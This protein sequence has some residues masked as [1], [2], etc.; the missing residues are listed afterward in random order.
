M[1]SGSS[2]GDTSKIESILSL[3]ESSVLIRGSYT[4]DI[5]HFITLMIFHVLLLSQ[6]FVTT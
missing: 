3:N 4:V 6:I 1:Q 5:N 2:S